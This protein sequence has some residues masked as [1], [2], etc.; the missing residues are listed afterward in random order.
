MIRINL[1]R[2]DLQE[3]AK[4][5]AA[6][7]SRRGRRKDILRGMYAVLPYKAAKSVFLVTPAVAGYLLHRYWFAPATFWERAFAYLFVDVP[8]VVLQIVVLV[9][10]FPGLKAKRGKG[11][12]GTMEKLLRRVRAASGER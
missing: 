1:L 6:R 5:A 4:I 3:K 8:F 7:N 11:M 2:E 12:P 10:F 9:L